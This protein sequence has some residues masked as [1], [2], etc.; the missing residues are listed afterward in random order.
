[1]TTR[2]PS[3]DE[4]QMAFV[5]W[6]EL[7]HIQF[8]HVNNEMWTKSWKQKVRSKEMGTQSGIPDLF[9]V[10]DGMMV[11]IEMKRT[12]NGTVSDNQKYWGVILETANIPVYCCRGCEHAIYTT[13]QII[14]QYG[15]KKVDQA[16]IDYANTHPKLREIKQKE[17]KNVN[18]SKK[19][20]KSGKDS[21]PY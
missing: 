19:Y 13:E 10:F 2:I 7:N 21:L 6:L 16:T 17:Q 3:E 1:M 5:D 15:L 20:Q 8:F 9:L 14:G 12:K 11:G 18:R 4:E